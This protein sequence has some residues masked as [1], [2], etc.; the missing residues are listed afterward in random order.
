MSAA[1]KL[2]TDRY[3]VFSLGKDQMALRLT[4]VREVIANAK[5]TPIP[6]APSHVKGIINLREKIISIVDLRTKLGR[7]K[8]EDGPETAIVILD[9]PG[10]GATGVIVDSVDRVV[11]FD[12]EK[13]SSTENLPPGI[14]AHLISGIARVEQELVLII[15][16]E[17]A[18][19]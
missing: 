12:D 3:L 10:N 13:I 15:N 18:V 7:N 17:N 19:A 8:S 16:I 14:A 6:K 11:H 2:D 5:A 9:Q 1:P 4:S